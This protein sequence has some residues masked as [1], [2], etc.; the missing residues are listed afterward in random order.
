MGIIA[1][2]VVPAVGLLLIGFAANAANY[3]FINETYD[4]P[5]LAVPGGWDYGPVADISRQYVSQGVGGS[6]ALQT[7]ATLV[8]P[9]FC[10]VTTALFQSG[11][12]GGNDWATRQNS[13]LSFDIKVDQPGLLAVVVYLDGWMEFVWNLGDLAGGHY[14][15]AAATVPLGSY[16][17]GVFQRIVLDLDD[18]LWHQNLWPDPNNP[19]PFFEPSARTFNNIALT[20][21]SD[22]LPALGP[23]TVTVDNVQVSTKNAMVPFLGSGTGQVEIGPEGYMVT[24]RGT[25]EHLGKYQATYEIPFDLPVGA[26]QITAANG[27]QLV[28]WIILGNGDFCILVDHGT[29]RF[30]GAVGSYRAAVVWDFPNYTASLR[31]ALSTVGWNKR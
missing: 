11:V 16:I 27:D 18:P 5:T 17:P 3:V 24:E 2:C 1:R 15:A 6:T 29:G 26:A 9:G 10:S 20:V 28:G 7:S 23:F 12:V 19:P 25:A 30:Q 22:G 21:D 4:P 8:G 14:I 13:V 31:G